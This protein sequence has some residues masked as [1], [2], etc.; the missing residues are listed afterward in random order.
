M[1]GININ[2]LSVGI[3]IGLLPALIT[4]AVWV[5]REKFGLWN[6]AI[7]WGEDRNLS[8]G[9]TSVIS[10]RDVDSKKVE[11]HAAAAWSCCLI[12]IPSGKEPVRDLKIHTSDNV[13][14]WKLEPDVAGGKLERIGNSSMIII[15]SI[16]AGNYIFSISGI[17]EYRQHV[18]IDGISAVNSG[19]SK[20]PLRPL[21]FDNSNFWMSWLMF[22]FIATPIISFLLYVYWTLS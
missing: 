5:L 4:L 22:V 13:S 2:E 16:E 14:E 21:K 12:S 8:G 17:T 7:I 10:T 15:P 11:V 1:G 18:S 19:C 3:G 6:R 20:K 9:L